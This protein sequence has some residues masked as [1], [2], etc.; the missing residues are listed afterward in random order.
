MTK[1]MIS[2][3]LRS[4]IALRVKPRSQ[5][6]LVGFRMVWLHYVS[7]MCGRRTGGPAFR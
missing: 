1:L 5:V 4:E 6:T 3:P 7:G 2:Q